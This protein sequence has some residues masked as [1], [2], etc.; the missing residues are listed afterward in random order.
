MNTIRGYLMSN[1]MQA[2]LLVMLVLLSLE[3]FINLANQ[4]DELGTG[5]YDFMQAITYVL[6][7]LPQ[8]LYRLFPMAGLLGA[9]LGLGSMATYS[10]LIALQAAGISRRQIAGNVLLAGCALVIIATIIGEGIAPFTEHL[11]EYR[12]T[13]ATSSSQAFQTIHGFWVRDG[14][15]FI[16]IHNI[17]PDGHLQGISRYE[18][19][20]QNHLRATSYA[21]EAYYQHQA[22]IMAKV[23][24]SLISARGVQSHTVA[25]VHWNLSLSP[26]L[27]Q[28]SLLEPEQMS[29]KQLLVAI[30]YLKKN[31]LHDDRYNMAFWKRVMQPLASLVMIFLA[32]PFVFGPLRNSSTSSRFLMGTLTG[33]GFYL[34]NAF[35]APLSVVLQAPAWLAAF[36]PIAI[37]TGIA[38]LLLRYQV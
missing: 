8:Q 38:A 14:Q 22:W 16:H 13:F 37:F 31:A 3:V 20:K 6:L 30:N 26:R 2:T 29:L 23:R 5:D 4:L 11:A 27:L 24:Q 32:V 35:F 10:E 1:V 9:L 7:D 28:L 33:F 18:F 15:S 34:L 19:D 21:E 17:L 36:I 25:Q 12:K